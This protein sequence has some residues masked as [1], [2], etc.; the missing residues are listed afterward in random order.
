MKWLKHNKPGMLLLALFMTANFSMHAQDSTKL[1]LNLDLKYF[2]YD[3]KVPFVTAQTRVKV[4]KKFQ[5]VPGIGI[6]VYLDTVAEDHLIISAVSND[7]GYVTAVL[8]PALKKIWDAANTHKFE[9]STVATGEYEEAENDL[10]ISKARLLLDTLSDDDGKSLK[11]TVQEWKGNDWSP[12][13]GVEVKAGI[14]RLGGGFLTVGK[15]D[16]YTTDS[17]GTVVAAFERDSLLSGPSGDLTLVA[18]VEDN[19]QFGNLVVE[20]PVNWGI[21]S[22]YVSDYYRRTLFS[23]RDKA[24]VWLLFMAY[25]ITLSV[26]G[27]LIYLIGQLFLINK[28]GKR[29]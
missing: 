16:S 15:D 28:L 24:P 18:K 3:N 10:E 7:E 8:P 27:V 9:A 20:K 29:V 12:V 2:S 25:T 22:S 4:K 26:W 14:R 1:N 11:L 17:T 13:K 5:A 19:D 6:K 21:A 23:T